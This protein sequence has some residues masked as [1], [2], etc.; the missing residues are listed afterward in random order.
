[1]TTF[2]K[3]RSSGMVA[4]EGLLEICGAVILMFLML[5]TSVDVVGRYVFNVPARGAFELTELTLAIL[6]FAGLPLVSR[7][8]EHVVVDLLEQR[9]PPGF[10]R[11]MDRAANLVSAAALV[12][13]AYL[14]AVKAERMTRDGDYTSVLKVPY[15]PFVFMMA[16]LVIICAFVHLAYA[17]NPPVPP[18]QTLEKTI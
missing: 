12:G 6:I 11:V 18:E 10:R 2:A 5:L 8:Q 16:V 3:L 17:F 7:H 15:A 1:M 9:M 4:L 14:L 13:L